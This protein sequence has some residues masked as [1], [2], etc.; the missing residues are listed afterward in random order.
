[1]LGELAGEEVPKVGAI[2]QLDVD[3]G[4][5]LVI[6]RSPDLETRSAGGGLADLPSWVR[7]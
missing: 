2:L 4:L 6:C 7:H 5:S 1:M 3:I